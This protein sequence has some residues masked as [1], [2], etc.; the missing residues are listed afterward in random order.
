M[1]VIL[2]FILFLYWCFYDSK[3]ILTENE[4]KAYQL[5]TRLKIRNQL[6]DIHSNIIFHSLKM[7]WIT[8]K[9]KRN[10]IKEKEYEMEYNFEKRCMISVIYENKI[11]SE[12]IKSFDII[13]TKYQLFDIAERIDIVIKEIKS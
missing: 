12:K 5:I 11:L 1:L 10:I 6:K 9:F 3:K 7:I 13:T 2:E 8:R 4:Q